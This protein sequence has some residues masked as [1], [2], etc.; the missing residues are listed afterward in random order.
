[1]WLL[2]S[3]SH[4]HGKYNTVTPLY[5]GHQ[6]D[7][8]NCRLYRGVLKERLDCSSQSAF[9]NDQSS[10]TSMHAYMYYVNLGGIC[11]FLITRKYGRLG[12]SKK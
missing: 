5:Y 12:I 1:M 10:F 4:L 6:R 7:R 9:Y 2:L 3:C 11:F 8:T